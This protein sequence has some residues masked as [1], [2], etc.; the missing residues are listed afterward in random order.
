[1]DYDFDLPYFAARFGVVWLM[2]EI[3]LGRSIVPRFTPIKSQGERLALLGCFL[4]LLIVC[5]LDRYL[6][7]K[8]R[9]KGRKS[10]IRGDTRHHRGKE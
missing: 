7:S 3:V 10:S 5:W 1:M 8:S 9:P 6:G 2:V 4:L